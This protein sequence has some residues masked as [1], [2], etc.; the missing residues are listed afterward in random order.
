MS[1]CITKQI[2]YKGFDGLWKLDIN[3]D[4]IVIKKN[5]QHRIYPLNDI[6]KV[7]H[8]NEYVFLSKYGGGFYQLKFE[9]DN[10]LVIDEF[11]EDGDHVDSIGSHVF[12]E[13]G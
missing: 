5:G 4:T 9:H 11:D 8:D 2:E 6:T 12:E 1:N 13:E 10:F 3:Y 7:E